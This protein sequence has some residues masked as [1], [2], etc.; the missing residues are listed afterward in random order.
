MKA[1]LLPDW[2]TPPRFHPKQ[3]ELAEKT[4]RALQAIPLETL[5]NGLDEI[6]EHMP[7]EVARLG[8]QYNL[9]PRNRNEAPPT[10]I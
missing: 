6:E 2:R 4:R 10:Q 5:L 1:D 8:A 3:V 7:E 9:P